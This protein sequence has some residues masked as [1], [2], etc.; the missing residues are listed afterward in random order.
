[1]CGPDHSK[2][3]DAKRARRGKTVDANLFEL[4]LHILFEDKT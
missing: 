1:M 4:Q 2:Q 3:R